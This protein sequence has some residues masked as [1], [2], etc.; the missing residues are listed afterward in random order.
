[1]FNC[2]KILVDSGEVGSD[3][4]KMFFYLPSITGRSEEI[5]QYLKNVSI[6]PFDISQQQLDIWANNTTFR[7]DKLD[8]VD[9]ETDKMKK[10]VVKAL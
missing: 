2:H 3:M 7:P 9:L 8:A 1:M 10:T 4:S 6:S 5:N